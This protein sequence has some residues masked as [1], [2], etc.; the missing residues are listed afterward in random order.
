V[1]KSNLS[2]R[3]FRL[4][5]SSV[6]W[7]FS[8]EKKLDQILRD[9]KSA[10]YE[11]VELYTSQTE[12]PDQPFESLVREI[13]NLIQT[14]G[15]EIACVNGYVGFGPTTRLGDFVSL[16]NV[17]DYT[18][19]LGCDKMMVVA[20]GG[21]RKNIADQHKAMAHFLNE[22][23]EYAQSKNVV[24]TVHHRAESLMETMKEIDSFFSYCTSENI[25]LTLDTGHLAA[26]G[27]D[28]VKAARIYHERGLLNHVHLKEGK[29][30]QYKN[31]NLGE[32]QVDFEKLIGALT[33]IGYQGWAVL[34][35]ESQP[36]GPS[37]LDI[38]R[39]N[40]QYL[41]KIL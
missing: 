23:A 25:K 37:P 41:D 24:V 8:G 29:P 27:D 16:K 18:A 31:L 32:G 34:E 22:V 28:P 36:G 2:E 11:G 15:L 9:I 30:G 12:N 1:G 38:A 39:V 13:K 33:N 3:N 7:F 4:G 19:A 26:T 20:L 35:L 6:T 40:K 17:V 14:I 5:C 10:G 21:E